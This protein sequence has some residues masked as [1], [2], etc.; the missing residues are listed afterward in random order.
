MPTFAF[1]KNKVKL[2]QLQGAS[3]QPLENLIKELLGND[4]GE[5]GD[6]CIVPGHVNVFI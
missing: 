5:D 3:P 6:S 1:Y 4:L 2:R